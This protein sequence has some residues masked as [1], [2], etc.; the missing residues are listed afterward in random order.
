MITDIHF[1]AIEKIKNKS[2]IDNGYCRSYV[3]VT[4]IDNAGDNVRDM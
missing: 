2:S 1:P 4:F 3:T